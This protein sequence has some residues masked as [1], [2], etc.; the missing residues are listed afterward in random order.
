MNRHEEHE[1]KA[2]SR[3]KGHI[4]PVTRIPVLAESD[5]VAHMPRLLICAFFDSLARGALAFVDCIKP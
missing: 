4:L 5:Q 2:A 3:D 1:N